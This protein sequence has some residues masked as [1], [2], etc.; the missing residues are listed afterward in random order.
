MTSP[1]DQKPRT[2]AG[3]AWRIR[4][5]ID[6]FAAGYH[7]A[8][9]MPD[10]IIG[11]LDAAQARTEALDVVREWVTSRDAAT[12][13]KRTFSAEY[14]AGYDT[15]VDEVRAILARETE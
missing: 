11:T 7:T 15:A 4:N 8:D 10:L 1:S 2:E 5:L 14:R 3:Q 6:Q 12:W 9:E 13:D